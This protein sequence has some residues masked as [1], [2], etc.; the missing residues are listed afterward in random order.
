MNQRDTQTTTNPTRD[1]KLIRQVVETQADEFDRE[2]LISLGEQL[3]RG[4]GVSL[5]G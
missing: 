1:E 3:M 5:N 4:E 2:R